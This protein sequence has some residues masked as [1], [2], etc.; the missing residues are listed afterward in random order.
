[1]A[2]I[3]TRVTDWSADFSLRL[4][5]MSQAK[6][7][8]PIYNLFEQ[9]SAIG[10]AVH[11]RRPSEFGRSD[12]GTEPEHRLQPVTITDR[13]ASQTG[14]QTLGQLEELWNISLRPLRPLRF[15]FMLANLID[16]IFTAGV[17]GERRGK[18]FNYSRCPLVCG[19]GNSHR[20]KSVLQ[21][22]L[23]VVF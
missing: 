20:L 3:R 23:H 19:I 21:P 9:I 22:V 13:F 4:L 10:L 16:F 15:K 11:G 7:C 6:A 1:M 17:A 18:P 12:F 2:E 14:A 5:P 8:A